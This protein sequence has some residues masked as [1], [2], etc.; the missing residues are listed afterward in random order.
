MKMD[1]AMIT[2][3]QQVVAEI[4][5]NYDSHDVLMAK[6]GRHLP[7]RS[8][9][10]LI[11]KEL[12]RIMFPGYFGDEDL[13][14]YVGDYFVGS[15]LNHVYQVL[16]EQIVT[17]LIYRQSD[18]LTAEEAQRQAEEICQYFISRLP[19]IQQMLLKDVQA[20]FDGDPAAQSK[21]DII[22][23]YPGLFAIYVYRV[24]HELY[25][26]QVPY[27]PRIM[28]EYAHSRTGIDINAGASIGE[29][30]FIDHGTGVV[31]GETTVIGNHVKL[32]QGVT[33]GALS[34]RMGQQ[35]A[36]VKRHPTIEDNV[37]IYSG[38]TILGGDTVIGRDTIIGG[39]AFITASVATETKVIVKN[40]EMTFKGG[41]KSELDMDAWV[42]EI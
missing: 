5:K 8:T 30:F 27:I 4:N 35:L 10:I 32:Y 39:N 20:G 12:R 2:Q 40:P 17:A 28:T 26:K 31:I 14:T 15:N 38:S 34:T 24:A 25:D 11:L 18:G 42:W 9:I 13:S 29:Y 19:Y 16:K 3:I 23:S 21:E 41:K 7:S 22:I 1:H 36:G 37:T 33:L 6:D